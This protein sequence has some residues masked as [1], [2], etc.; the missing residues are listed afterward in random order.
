VLGLKA[1]A[2][3]P[4][5]SLAL[6]SEVLALFQAIKKEVRIFSP[7]RKEIKRGIKEL[8]QVVSTVLTRTEAH[9]PAVRNYICTFFCFLQREDLTFWVW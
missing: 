3:T 4:G 2:T 1:C 8:A 6:L 5:F 7:R 9:Y